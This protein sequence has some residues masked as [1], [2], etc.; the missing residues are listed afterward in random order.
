MLQFNT[1]QIY[2]METL[3]II[4]LLTSQAGEIC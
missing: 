4:T 2:S 1:V 3:V